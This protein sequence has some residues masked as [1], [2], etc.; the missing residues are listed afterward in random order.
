VAA[1]AP[2]HHRVDHIGRQE[3][4]LVVCGVTRTAQVTLRTGRRAADEARAFLRTARCPAHV[5]AAALDDALLLVSELVTNAVRHGAP[6]LTLRIDCEESSGITV[7]VSDG[8]PGLPV[9]GCAHEQAESGRGMTLVD[10]ISDDW[11]A[12]PDAP[13]KTVWFRLVR[14]G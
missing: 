3:G 11:G 1:C 6:P 9:L 14:R 13:G 7:R 12:E 2:G 8:E 10:A 4:R 5:G